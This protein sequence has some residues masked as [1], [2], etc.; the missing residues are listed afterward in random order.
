MTIKKKNFFSS[1]LIKTQTSTIQVE[2]DNNNGRI[3]Y[4]NMDT[5][6]V[7]YYL[8]IILPQQKMTMIK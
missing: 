5:G 8:K 6:K 2:F 4:S 1:L 3:S 7:N